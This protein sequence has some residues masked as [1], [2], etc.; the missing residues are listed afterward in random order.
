MTCP[1]NKNAILVAMKK[2]AIV[3]QVDHQVQEPILSLKRV[4]QEKTVLHRTLGTTDS[5]KWEIFQAIEVM[6]KM[7][8]AIGVAL[9]EQKAATITLIHQAI[10]MNMQTTRIN[11]RQCMNFSKVL[12]II[13]RVNGFQEIVV[14]QVF[15][16]IIIDIQR[17]IMVA[18]GTMLLKQVNC[19]RI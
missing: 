8:Y 10:S 2:V 16:Q 5:N 18:T 12:A 14:A 15:I 9:L 19:Q 7:Q 11:S 6:S 4:G 13:K 17:S 1:T 3:T